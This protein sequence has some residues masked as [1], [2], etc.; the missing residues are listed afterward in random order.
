M[1]KI[2]DVKHSSAISC[3][4]YF[5]FFFCI[6]FRCILNFFIYFQLNYGREDIQIL[7]MFEVYL[8]GKQQGHSFQIEEFAIAKPQK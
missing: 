3:I 2:L 5:Y 7:K 6:S 1:C 8:E 4:F